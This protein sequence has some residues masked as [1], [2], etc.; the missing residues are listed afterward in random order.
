MSY[1]VP[2]L[3]RRAPIVFD[4]NDDRETLGA[5]RPTFN[6]NSKFLLK[7]GKPLEVKRASAER[8][9]DLNI[10]VNSDKQRLIFVPKNNVTDANILVSKINERT[11]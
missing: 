1:D 6:Q 3:L 9:I 5:L 11:N 10:L 2:L 7:R 4:V 8:S